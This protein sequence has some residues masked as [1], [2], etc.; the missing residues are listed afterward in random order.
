MSSNVLKTVQRTVVAALLV[1]TVA[2]CSTA[3]GTQTASYYG[4]SAGNWVDAA[5]V[6]PGADTSNL[7]IS[8]SGEGN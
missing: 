6:P 7:M 4:F 8:N 5:M 3:P 1:A 2:A